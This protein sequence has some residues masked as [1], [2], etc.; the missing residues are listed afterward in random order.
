ML[1]L[2]QIYKD[3]RV[4]NSVRHLLPLPASSHYTNPYTC[5][6]ITNFTISL[7]KQVPTHI[8]I[9]IITQLQKGAMVIGSSLFSYPK[10]LGI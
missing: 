10:F 9:I 3:V 5:P 6:L 4:M 8:S 7:A 2:V 1:A